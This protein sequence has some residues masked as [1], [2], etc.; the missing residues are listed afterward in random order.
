MFP[1]ETE[2]VCRKDFSCQKKGTKRAANSDTTTSDRF[3]PFPCS[4]KYLDKVRLDKI[5]STFPNVFSTE[6]VWSQSWFL[7]RCH[8]RYY[9]RSLHDLAVLSC[10]ILSCPAFLPSRVA[11]LHSLF[12]CTS[13]NGNG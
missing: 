1:G 11:C 3:L 9:T 10:P 4:Q 13:V 2:D 6:Y 12:S 8:T 7:I 5:Y